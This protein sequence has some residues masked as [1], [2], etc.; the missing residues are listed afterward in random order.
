MD[1]KTLKVTARVKVGYV[2][3]RNGTLLLRV[4]GDRRGANVPERR[5]R[6]PAIESGRVT[7][8][9][10]RAHFCLSNVNATCVTPPAVPST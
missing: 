2:P 5:A 9:P 8:F 6:R 3:K 7:G 4:A 1:I 10:A